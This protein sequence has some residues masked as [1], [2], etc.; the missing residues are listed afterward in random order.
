MA[1]NRGLIPDD[2]NLDRLR[3]LVTSYIERDS[4]TAIPALRRIADLLE[5]EGKESK[6]LL[7]L[8]GLSKDKHPSPTFSGGDEKVALISHLIDFMGVMESDYCMMKTAVVNEGVIFY[9]LYVGKFRSCLLEKMDELVLQELK[10][11]KIEDLEILI[12][13]VKTVT[14]DHTMLGLVV[15][16]LVSLEKLKRIEKCL[17]D[18]ISDGRVFILTR[19]FMPQPEVFPVVQVSQSVER[20]QHVSNA[21]KL[22]EFSGEFLD[23]VGGCSFEEL[24][25]DELE[26]VE[27]IVRKMESD[28]EKRAAVEGGEV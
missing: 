26:E 3:N 1:A 28:L 23:L 8:L 21:Q 7:Q 18:V 16:T 13:N 12:W 6:D 19:Q 14:L 9:R 22:I 25:M 11:Q 2:L 4:E 17:C 27:D 24:E 15:S 20:E 5:T 10:A